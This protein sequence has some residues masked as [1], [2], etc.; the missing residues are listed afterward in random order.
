MKIQAFL[1]YVGFLFTFF[2]VA[3]SQPKL[4]ELPAND[5]ITIDFEHVYKLGATK[6]YSIQ[7]SNIPNAPPI[8]NAYKLLESRS[9]FIKT[10]TIASGDTIFTF[11]SSAG[12]EGE[13]NKVHILE[14]IPN[15]INPSGYEWKDCTVTNE[16]WLNPVDEYISVDRKARMRKFL[17]SYPQKRI[18][19]MLDELKNDNYLVVSTQVATAPAEPFTQLKVSLDDTRPSATKGE[20]I[21]RL[22]FKNTGSKTLSEV[23]FL[24]SFDTDSSV[25]LTKPSQGNCR[26][27]ERGSGYD[28]IVCYLGALA[29]GMTATVELGRTSS[30]MGNGRPPLAKNQAPPPANFGWSISGFI[31]DSPDS[32]NWPANRFWLDPLAESSIN[33]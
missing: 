19:C 3:C 1:F 5:K 14:L 4:I 23:N 30:G 12:S 24:S 11:N 13:F 16:E 10:D 33:K 25:S 9:Y 26:K 2:D 15:E 21:Y 8:P 6:K 20:T 29:P 32:P 7:I 22:S 31:K 17:P 28:N 27:S 18:S